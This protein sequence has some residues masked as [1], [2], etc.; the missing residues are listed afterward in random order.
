MPL[1]FC[2]HCNYKTKLL[3]NYKQHLKLRNMFLI[4]VNIH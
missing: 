2:E 3:G 4:L 1:Y